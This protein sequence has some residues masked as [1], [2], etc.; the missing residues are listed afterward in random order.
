MCVHCRDVDLRNSL[1]VTSTSPAPLRSDGGGGDLR[2]TLVKLTASSISAPSDGVRA[3]PT[4]RVGDASAASPCDLRSTIKADASGVG[5][6]AARVTPPPRSDISQQVTPRRNSSD[7]QIEKK[8]E[9]TGKLVCVWCSGA[10]RD[11]GCPNVCTYCP[12]SEQ[13]ANGTHTTDRCKNRLQV[14]TYPLPCLFRYT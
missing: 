8:L 12:L 5:A 13:I 14:L 4:H 3:P 11:D 10:H 6:A 9:K 1:R 7:S 2:S